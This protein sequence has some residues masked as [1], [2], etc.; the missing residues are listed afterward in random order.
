[1]S[2]TRF[3]LIRTS[4]LGDIVQALP[5][6]TAL[7]RHHSEARIAWLVEETFAP[8]L[9]GH[10]DLDEIITVRLRAW[11]QTP[12][13]ART[14]NELRTFLAHLH[15]FSPDVV[16][17]LMGNHKAGFLASLTLA[18][19]RIGLA[20][21]FRREPSSAIWISE[22]VRADGSHA[23]DRM[24]SVLQALDLPREPADF[25][26]DKIPRADRSAVLLQDTP[27]APVVI[28]PGAGW[29][30]KRYP[31]EHWGEVARRLEDRLGRKSSVVGG[32]GEENL[33]TA[34][35]AASH[36]SAVELEAS[37][38]PDLVAVLEGAS[39]VLG[40]DTG[41]LHLAHA[42]GRPVLCLM[43]PTDPHLHGPYGSAQTV[44]W[45]HLPCSF[46]HRRY[47]DVMPCLADL[48]PDEVAERAIAVLEGVDLPAFGPT[49]QRQTGCR[50]LH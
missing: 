37:G 34:V 49:R 19:R 41:P 33:V 46:C 12:F 1:M 10:P 11:R 48:P 14:W 50:K 16:L 2:P 35:I 22:A 24:L 47:P 31:P 36:G 45:Q 29:A 44:V 42:L 18:D 32:P 30:N 7:R 28:L 43:G 21:S 40:G 38:I 20:R 15:R 9:Q 13:S 3:L 8:L 4:A 5:V 39:L 23:V 17:D 25:A 6:L 27:T 26:A